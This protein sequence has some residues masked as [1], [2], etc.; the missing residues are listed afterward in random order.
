MC[1]P[2]KKLYEGCGSILFAL[3]G[4]SDIKMPAKEDAFLFE[5]CARPFR[6][7]QTQRICVPAC[8]GD[9]DCQKGAF[10]N[11]KTVHCDQSD[12]T[13]A[14]SMPPMLLFAPGQE[15]K[16]A[17]RQAVKVI[18]AAAKFVAVDEDRDSVESKPLLSRIPPEYIWPAVGGAIIVL[19]LAIV[20]IVFWI[21][22]CC[23]RSSGK[24][25]T[26]TVTLDIDLSALPSPFQR[27]SEPTMPKAKTEGETLKKAMPK[28]FEPSSS[29][30][31][32]PPPPSYD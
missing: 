8:L 4:Q 14:Y 11:R 13:C 25:S 20:L 3:E 30:S 19:V 28:L 7:S 26:R 6:C 15:P 2:R 23:H 9:L 32:L 12:F 17:F 24:Y 18:N 29:A 10:S 31:N 21:K 22:K 5:E 16:A 1:R 27:V